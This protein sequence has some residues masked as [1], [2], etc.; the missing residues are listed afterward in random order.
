MQHAKSVTLNRTYPPMA[1][2]QSAAESLGVA[3]AQCFSLTYHTKYQHYY[4]CP[5]EWARH[6]WCSNSL[7]PRQLS[8]WATKCAVSLGGVITGKRVLGLVWQPE[9]ASLPY[10]RVTDHPSFVAQ[11]CW[12]KRKGHRTK[13]RTNIGAEDHHRS[14]IIRTASL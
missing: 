11:C 9:T 4:R 1:K 12:P 3:I 13:M 6:R 10:C 14:M 8:M 7:R 5:G 2:V